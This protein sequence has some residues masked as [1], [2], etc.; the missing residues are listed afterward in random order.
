AHQP[1]VDDGR[2]AAQVG[3]EEGTL[4]PGAPERLGTGQAG[5]DIPPPDAGN[6]AQFTGGRQGLSD[7]RL[8]VQV[9]QPQRQSVS[10]VQGGQRCPPQYQSALNFHCESSLSWLEHRPG[11]ARRAADSH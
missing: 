5:A 8:Q 9:A 7:G 1:T 10:A 4:Y 2:Y 6:I 11:L 3:E